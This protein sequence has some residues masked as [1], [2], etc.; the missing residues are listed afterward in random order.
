MI[1]FDC[2]ATTLQKPSSVGKAAVTAMHAAASP[3]RG[4]HPAAMKAADLIF[5]CRQAAA[6][7]FEVATPDQVVLTS[8]ATHGLNIAIKTLVKPGGSAL[9]SGYEHNAVTRPLAA[10]PGVRVR[11]VDTPLFQ[12]EVFLERFQKELERETPGCVIC[13]H[14]SNVFGYVLPVE[15]VAELCKAHKVPLILDASQAAGVQPISMEKLGAAFIAMPG[16]KSL[17][18]PQGTGLLLCGKDQVGDPLLEGGTGSLSAQPTMPDFLPDRLEAGTHNVPGAAGLL[19]GIRFVQET[20]LR[21]IRSHENRLKAMAADGLRK[22]SPVEVF[23]KA[24]PVQAG[25]LSFRVKGMDCSAVG[26]LLS[27][28]QIAVR[29][30]LHCAP[31]AH[32]TAGTQE[33]GTVRLSFSAFNNEREVEAFLKVMGRETFV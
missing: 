5:A 15:E 29:T 8:N 27:R 12:P 26:D 30:G 10:I 6:R 22:L 28:R 11:V 21:N 33:T 1:Y 16:H 31:L 2:A 14:V 25:V 24:G 23:D 17:Y 20:G 18:G 7:L 32:R 19:Q 9:I 4:S 13:T 3:G